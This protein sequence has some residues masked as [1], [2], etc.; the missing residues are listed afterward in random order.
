MT[1]HPQGPEPSASLFVVALAAMLLFFVFIGGPLLAF[2][3]GA[4]PQ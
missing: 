1:T 4:V 2:L 3:L